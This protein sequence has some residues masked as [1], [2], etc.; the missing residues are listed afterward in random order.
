MPSL[1]TILSSV[2]Y[3][4]TKIFSLPCVAYISNRSTVDFLIFLMFHFILSLLFTVVFNDVCLIVAWDPSNFTY[5]PG[6]NYEIVWQD[7][8]E[9]VGPVKATING[10]PA[11]SPNPENWAFYHMQDAGSQHYVDSIYNAYVQNGQLTIVIMEPPKY[12]SSCLSSENLQEFTFAVFAAKIRLPYGKGLWPAW[13]LLGHDHKYG[14]TRPTTGEIDILEMWGGSHVTNFTDQIAHATCHFNNQSYSMD[15]L[16]YSTI[17]REWQTPDNSSLHNNSLVYWVEWTPTKL[18][19]GINEFAYFQL[20][21][22]DVPNSINPPAAF[23]GMFSYFMRL[24]IAIT[25]NSLPDETNVWPQQMIVDWVRVYQ[26][27]KR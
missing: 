3:F 17:S 25:R 26:E 2:N 12:N 11:Y 14:L 16:I 18:N 22:T 15:P 1:F 10:Q 19:M 7:E 23:S 20:N 5:N 13:W 24:N 6:D 9:N 4:E 21:T 8:F 27:K